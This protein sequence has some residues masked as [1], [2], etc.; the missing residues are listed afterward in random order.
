M[1]STIRKLARF[2]GTKTPRQDRYKTLK[3]EV[4][5]DRIMLTAST[6]QAAA[7]GNWSV[8]GNWSAGIPGVTTG[9]T[10]ADFD[11]TSAKKATLTGDI[12]IATLSFMLGATSTLSLGGFHLT[13][14]NG[15]QLK[16]GAIT[17]SRME[18]ATL[19]SCTGV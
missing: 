17:E 12:N 10:E 8:A 4:L 9:V 7:D 1:L 14:S 16:G 18:K 19:C 3:V 6:W 13:V 11:N 15:G 5:G 2:F